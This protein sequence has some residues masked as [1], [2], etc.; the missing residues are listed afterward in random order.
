[1]PTCGRLERHPYSGRASRVAVNARR[2]EGAVFSP[3]LRAIARWTPAAA[4]AATAAAAA[5]QRTVDKP[6]EVHSQIIFL[7]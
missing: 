5:D 6:E 4:A 7:V 3:A 2:E 1:M